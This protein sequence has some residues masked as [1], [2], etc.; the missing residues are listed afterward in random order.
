MTAMLLRWWRW[1]TAGA[2]R[3]AMVWHCWLRAAAAAPSHSV[4]IAASG[5]RECATGMARRQTNKVI[6]YC[7]RCSSRRQGTHMRRF[8]Q[9]TGHASLL[10]VT[11]TMVP[12][13]LRAVSATAA[14]YTVRLPLGRMK[15]R[16]EHC[17]SHL[18]AGYFRCSSSHTQIA[19]FSL[20][21]IPLPFPIPHLHLPLAVS[22]SIH[23]C[24]FMSLGV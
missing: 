14:C 24:F 16:A 6:C 11:R 8:S 15:S 21:R 18:Q 3:G 19:S 12:L 7:S 9:I 1:L 13:M 23:A 17:H 2:V 20:V 10:A 5:K 4:T 22:I